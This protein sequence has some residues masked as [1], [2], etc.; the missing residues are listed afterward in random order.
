LHRQRRKDFFFEKKE[1]KNFD[2]FWLRPLRIGSAQF[3]KVFAA[4]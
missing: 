2:E 4:F 1:A 3:V